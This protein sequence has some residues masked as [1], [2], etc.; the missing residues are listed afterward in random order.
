MELAPNHGSFAENNQLGEKS[1]GISRK[2]PARLSMLRG[3]ALHR[4][5]YGL[6]ETPVYLNAEKA[7]GVKI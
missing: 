3:R 5:N 4:Q 6:A 7:V 2:I 1:A